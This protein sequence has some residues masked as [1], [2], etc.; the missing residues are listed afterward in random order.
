MESKHDIQEMGMNA[1]AIQDE[2]LLEKA[3]SLGFVLQE[4]SLKN[5][6]SRIYSKN[7]KSFYPIINTVLNGWVAGWKIL[8][9]AFK[10]DI[11]NY[12]TNLGFPVIWET[13]A[14][15]AERTFLQDMHLSGFDVNY[16]D[17]EGRLTVHLLFEALKY[18]KIKKIETEKIIKT[19]KWLMGKHQDIYKVYPG[20]YENND[21][22]KNGHNI[23]TYALMQERWDIAL[24]I[25]PNSFQEIIKTPRWEHAINYLRKYIKNFPDDKNANDVWDKFKANYSLDYVNNSIYKF[26]DIDGIK[27]FLNSQLNVKEALLKKWAETNKLNQNTWLT[28]AELAP[29]KEFKS[30]IEYLELIKFNIKSVFLNLDETDQRPL[31][32]FVLSYLNE[33][34][35]GLNKDFLYSFINKFKKEDLDYKNNRRICTLN[36]VLNEYIV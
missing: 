23:F 3:L 24:L 22:F 1:L 28:I 33:Y 20:D 32:V 16:M 13:S 10:Q 15:N 36:E 25:M 21:V 35:E 2:V 29:T 11:L 12:K 31:D 5:G 9:P 34:K 27:F 4:Y 8:F 17:G 26:S 7:F 30:L 18:T 19:L 6:E 14:F